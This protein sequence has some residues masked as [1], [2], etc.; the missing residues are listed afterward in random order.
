MFAV[1]P[2]LVDCETKLRLPKLFDVKVPMLLTGHVTVPIAALPWQSV[3]EL[4]ATTSPVI[5]GA[6]GVGLTV[7]FRKIGVKLVQP[8]TGFVQTTVYW[9]TPAVAFG[10]VK[11]LLFAVEPITWLP[12]NTA[13]PL[14]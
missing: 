6:S 7:T 8:V 9:N 1:A 13:E 12:P 5:T 10:I 11:K 4:P 3:T 2:G 14:V